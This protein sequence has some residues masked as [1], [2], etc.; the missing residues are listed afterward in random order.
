MNDTVNTRYDIQQV[1]TTKYEKRCMQVM[2][3]NSTKSLI[4]A[5]RIRTYAGRSHLISSQTP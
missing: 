3:F 4:A 1:V 2:K 5:S